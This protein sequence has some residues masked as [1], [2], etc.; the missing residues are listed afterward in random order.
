[1][2]RRDAKKGLASLSIG[3]MGVALA[4]DVSA[5]GRRFPDIASIRRRT[6][7]QKAIHALRW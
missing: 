1:M 2:A 6:S 7:W 5:G 3:G 4:I